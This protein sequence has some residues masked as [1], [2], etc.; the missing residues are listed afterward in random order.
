MK[1]V[2]VFLFFGCFSIG[3]SQ[4]S[5]ISSGPM[6]GYCEFKEAAIWLQTNKNELVKIDYFAL[7]NPKEVFSSDT[8]TSSKENGFTYHIILDK[9]QPGKKYNYTLVINNKK[10]VLPYETSFSSKKIWQYRTDAPDFKVAF[11][12]CTYINE[13]DVDRPGKPYGSGYNIFE[14][15]NTKNPDIMLWGGD[16]IYLREVDFDSKTGIYHRYKHSRGIKEFQPLLA[17]TQNFAL[18]DDHDFGPNDSDRS[19]Y[20]KYVTQQAFKDF[21]ANKSYGSNPNQKE[22]TYSTFNWN[23]AQFFLLD[24]RFFRSPNDRITGEK[25]MLGKDQL[26][27]LID[28]LAASKA[29]FKIIV[30]GGQ[31]LN[32]VP[33]Y[34][35]YGTYPDEKARI[36]KELIDNKIKGVLFLTGDR[37]FAELSMMKRENTYPIYDWTVSPFTSGVGS[38]SAKTEANEFKVDGSVFFE[39]NFGTLEF[40]GNKENRQLKLVLYNANGKELW[41]RIILK[42]ELE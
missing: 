11:G 4:N 10:V 41:N 2:L 37:H 18:W 5:L 26:E 28:G 1:K 13:T 34:E 23:D 6:V 36:F 16:N 32:S 24:D 30:I 22:G 38:Q 14:S 39:H 15:I 12:S 21:W 25:T 7:D 17:K 3:F 31:V 27:W 9:L 35:N 8:Y 29:N 19:F 40:S 33:D 20:N 42:K